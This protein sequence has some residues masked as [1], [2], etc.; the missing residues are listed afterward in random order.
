MSKYDNAGLAMIPSGYKA[1]KV[2]SVIPN[3]ADGDFDFS[4]ASTATRVNKDG[5]I[6]S[7]A[8]GTP[9]LD[10]PLIEGVVQDCPALLLEPA[11]TNLIQYSEDF[12]NADWTKFNTTVTAD[13]EISPDGTNTAYE[14]ESTDASHLLYVTSSV[15]QST[16]YIFSFF[17]KEGTINDTKIAFYDDTANSFILQDADKEV[18]DY[19]NGWKRFIA[20]V[21]TP[22]GCTS[23]YS[24]IDRSSEVGSFYTWGAQLEQGSYPT[25]YIPTSGS[26]VTRAAETC[27]GAGTSDTF[28]ASEGI[29]FVEMAALDR[30][31]SLF[32]LISLSD[33]TTTNRMYLGFASGTNK[34]IWLYGAN[35]FTGE[36]TSI[37]TTNNNKIAFKFKDNDFAIWVNGVEIDSQLSGSTFSSNTFNTMGFDSGSGSSTTKLYANLKQLMTFNKALTDSELE[38]L[39]SWDS[40][41]EL[42]QGQQYKTY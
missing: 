22:S 23:L 2:Y 21:T 4:R 30:Q 16:K 19:P 20:E 17:F 7:V 24:Y 5:L 41:I 32:E 39:T 29:L 9:R 37:E 33:G 14:V 28:N 12:T 27:N 13:Q 25:S 26:A 10:Y 18:I 42:A 15:S 31:K 8:T 36:T 11:R 38:D 6:E 3:T 40:F 35:V 1:S 34:L